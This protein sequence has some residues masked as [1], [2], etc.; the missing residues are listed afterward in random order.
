[1]KIGFLNM[2]LSD[3][4]IEPGGGGPSYYERGL[5]DPFIS[6]QELSQY[7][8]DAADGRD[9]SS[10]Q[11]WLFMCGHVFTKSVGNGNCPQ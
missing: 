4:D 7:N 1:M 11:Y 3:M 9:D 8:M 10:F 5:R 6:L 2:K